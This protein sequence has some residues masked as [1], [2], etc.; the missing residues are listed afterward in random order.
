MKEKPA[1]IGANGC[2]IASALDVI[3]DRWSLMIVREAL[4]GKQRRFGEFQRSLGIAKNHL[5]A[6]LERPDVARKRE[7]WKARQASVDPARW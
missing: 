2:A 6:R 7:R 1:N 5:S 4:F 3:G